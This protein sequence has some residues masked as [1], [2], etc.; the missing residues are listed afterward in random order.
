VLS[1]S[2]VQTP[3]NRTLACEALIQ[4]GRLVTAT[5]EPVNQAM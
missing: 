3:V 1:A 2:F 4:P 5:C